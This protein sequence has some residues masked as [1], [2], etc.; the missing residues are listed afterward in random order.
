MTFS[1]PEEKVKKDLECKKSK[2]TLMNSEVS[3]ID[4][5]CANYNIY[6]IV[7]QCK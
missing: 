3:D 5:P 7:P 2:F 6:I 4:I 1:I